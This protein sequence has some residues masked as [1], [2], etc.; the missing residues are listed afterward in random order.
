MDTINCQS[1]GSPIFLVNGVSVVSCF[2]TKQPMT[3]R[4]PGPTVNKVVDGFDHAAFRILVRIIAQECSTEDGML[5]SYGNLLFANAIGLM[6][7]KGYVHIISQAGPNVKAQW[8]VT[9][10][11]DL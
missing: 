6:E 10:L 7:R 3:K 11:N 4:A 9:N 2:C 8:V 5:S 1:C